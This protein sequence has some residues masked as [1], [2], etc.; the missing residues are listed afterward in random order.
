MAVGEAAPPHHGGGL[1][2][3]AARATLKKGANVILLK[4]C[5]NEQTE[6]WAQ[7]WRFQLRVCE[8]IGAAVSFTTTKLPGAAK[9]EEKE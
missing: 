2:Q 3:Y 8:P 4:V 6:M 5:Q 9:K 1:D 7:D